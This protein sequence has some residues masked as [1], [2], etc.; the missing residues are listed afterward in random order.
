M[1]SKPRTGLSLYK[2]AG[3]LAT[4]AIAPRGG[5]PPRLAT[6]P[7]TGDA[8][9]RRDNAKPVK[10]ESEGARNARGGGPATR[11]LPTAFTAEQ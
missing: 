9:E 10:V 11:H 5:G 1:K 8:A 6:A 2:S 3:S 7:L 4:V